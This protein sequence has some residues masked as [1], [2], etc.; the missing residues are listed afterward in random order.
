MDDSG[1]LFP[2]DAA[3]VVDVMEQRV[4][5]RS[6]RMARCRMD[7]HTSRLVDNDQIMIL[8]EDWKWER[9]GLWLRL[10]RLR[11][12]DNHRL[13]GLDRLIGFGHTAADPYGLV[14]DEALNLRP[15]SV[16]DH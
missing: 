11:H 8:V 3:Q 10:D 7:D 2:A 13:P 4:D 6:A 5:E 15:G 14:F 9:F 12:I 1:A 16:G